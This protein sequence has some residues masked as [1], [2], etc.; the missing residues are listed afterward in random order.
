MLGAMFLAW[1]VTVF[2]LLN[3]GVMQFSA[4][5]LLAA[6]FVIAVSRRARWIPALLLLPAIPYA[7]GPLYGS[8]LGDT[9]WPFSDGAEFVRAT[10]F[11]IST[12]YVAVAVPVAL[13]M[14]ARLQRQI[15]ES[16]EGVVALSS[17]S[18]VRL[19]S[20]ATITVFAV[21][22]WTVV[23]EHG[24]L[25]AGRSRRGVEMLLWMAST[26]T[27]QM[28]AVTATVLTL[29]AFT[30]ISRVERMLQVLLVVSMWTPFLLGGGRRIL[31]YA[32]VP[33][34]II[35][36]V[37]GSRITR[38]LVAVAAGAGLVWFFVVPMAY[39]GGGDFAEN[40]HGEW[41]MAGAPFIAQASGALSVGDVGAS[42]WP[43]NIVRALPDWLGGDS[44]KVLADALAHETTLYPTGTSGSIWSDV[45]V[46]DAALSTLGLI[47]IVLVVIYV[48]MLLEQKIPGTLVLATGSFAL[49]GRTHAPYAITTIIVPAMVLLAAWLLVR[50]KPS[51]RRSVGE[52]ATSDPVV[53]TTTPTELAS[54]SQLPSNIG[55]EPRL[56]QP[57]RAVRPK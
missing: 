3:L 34:V 41:S 17:H 55:E 21:Q 30:R 27:G 20:A 37:A 13:G 51:S 35:L 50:A 31:L 15:A 19:L 16:V 48:P 6:G 47:S 11:M 36:Y 29:A 49:L 9:L 7:I 40:G 10:F 22:A 1:G 42:G 46:D 8:A 56:A 28:L 38:Q 43:E 5:A 23:A 32:A 26:L 44:V 45:W 2:A 54:D 24:V 52:M 4:V 14:E 39:A 25:T 12:L 57:R 53:G 18:L 33:A